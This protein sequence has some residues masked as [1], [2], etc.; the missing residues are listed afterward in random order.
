MLAE[1]LA[2]YE[3]ADFQGALK[4]VRSKCLHVL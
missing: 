2:K 1:L 3:D 4:Q